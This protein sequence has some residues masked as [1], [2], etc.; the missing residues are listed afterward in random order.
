MS[1][2]QEIVKFSLYQ[3]VVVSLKIV[4]V[5][6]HTKSMKITAEINNT[7]INKTEELDEEKTLK[8]LMKDCETIRVNEKENK[9]FVLDEM[10]ECEL[11]DKKKL[12]LEEVRRLQSR[13]IGMILIVK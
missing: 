6:P 9:Y 13:F 2:Q 3:R 10:K 1:N 7:T 8:E 5:N 12:L 11:I 4:I